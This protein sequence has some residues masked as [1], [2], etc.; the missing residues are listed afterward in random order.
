[1]PAKFELVKPSGEKI[2]LTSPY[3]LLSIDGIG[4]APVEHRSERG[5]FQDGETYL[6]TVLRPRVITF[7]LALTN[8]E[9][10]IWSQRAELEALMVSL[11]DGFGLLATLPDGSQRKL[12]LRFLGGLDLPINAQNWTQYQPAV[13]QA[14]AHRPLWF[15][16]DAVIWSYALGAGSGEWGFPLGFPAGFGTSDIDVEES[17]HYVGTWAA[18]PI[19]TVDGPVNNLVIENVTTDEKLDFTGYNLASGN[20]MT[21]DLSYG[22]KTAKL[23]DGTSVADKLTTDSDLA[24]WHIAAHPEATNGY[25]TIAITGAAANQDTAITFQFYTQYVGI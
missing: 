6:G 8:P 19:I 4:M 5:P 15:D 3:R 1:M 21:I 24:T 17:K 10:D 22:V 25:N 20:T 18:Y 7:K 23:Q 13:F 9:L 14:V 11:T 12:T 2:E 16:P